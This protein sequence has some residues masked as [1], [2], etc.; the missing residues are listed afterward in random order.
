MSITVAP[1]LEKKVKIF[2]Y[3]FYDKIFANVVKN[4]FA[5]V[6]GNNDSD[7]N[8]LFSIYNIIY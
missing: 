5:I 6:N 8:E 3:S 7:D 4:S 2:F 1:Y